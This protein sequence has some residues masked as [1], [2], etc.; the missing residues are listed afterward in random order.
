MQFKTILII[1]NY[2]ILQ[3][4]GN[5]VVFILKLPGSVSESRL[6]SLTLITIYF[7]C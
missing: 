3:S 6:I 1:F 7:C 4:Q 2:F 5:M